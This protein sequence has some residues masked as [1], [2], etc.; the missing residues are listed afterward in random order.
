MILV[1]LIVAWALGAL[2]VAVEAGLRQTLE[3][4][5]QAYLAAGVSGKESELE[6]WMSVYRLSAMKNDLARARRSLTPEM[7]QGIARYSPGNAGAEFVALLE[8]GATAGLVYVRD[9][10]ET[11]A[12]G[13]PRV[14]F[15]F[16][17]F[18]R[19]SSGWKVDGGITIGSPKFQ[20]DGKKAV[21]DPSRLPPTYEIDGKVRGVQKPDPLP[22]VSAFVD[23]FCP[24]Y[25]V[26]LT[27][28]GA[29]Q[30]TFTDKNYSGLLKGGLRIGEN[31]IVIVVK[32]VNGEAPFRPRL[33]IRRVLE[34]RT[35]REVFTF[36]AQEN[37]EVEHL[38]R[39]TIKIR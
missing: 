7:I 28:N 31:L 16:I 22:E 36:E 19:E 37:S 4:V 34:D 38:H 9:A 27:V 35:T 13:K 6:K 20:A 1:A 21:F 11:D 5:W 8:K 12:A 18:V 2:G 32:R 29:A 17:K 14:N 30:E 25:S 15:I 23:V 3:K 33:K 39:F 24:G 10:E 26:A